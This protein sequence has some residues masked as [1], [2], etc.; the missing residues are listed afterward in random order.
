MSELFHYFGAIVIVL[1]FS[2][3]LAVWRV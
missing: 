2:S 3:F 1:V